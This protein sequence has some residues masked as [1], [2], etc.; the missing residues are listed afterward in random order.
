M[1]DADYAQIKIDEG[2]K[3]GIALVRAAALRAGS[4][5]GICVDCGEVIH[6]V[7]L[8]AVPWTTRC[9]E[10]QELYESAT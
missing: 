9:V 5:D 10:C 3:K 2:L 1:D 4:R 7:R 8:E 6:P